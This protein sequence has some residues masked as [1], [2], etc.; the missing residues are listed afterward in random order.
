MGKN[1]PVLGAAVAQSR[2]RGERLCR[3]K[4][5]DL[6]FEVA[7]AKCLTGQM[8]KIDRAAL[9]RWRPLAAW[10]GE[11]EMVNGGA[12]H[13]TLPFTQFFH[14]RANAWKTS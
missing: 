14:C 4:R 2:P 12:R 11:G 3:E 1:L 7:I 6:L 5:K 8:D 10:F 9:G 13:A